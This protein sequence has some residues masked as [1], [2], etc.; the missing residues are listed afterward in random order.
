MGLLDFAAVLLVLFGSAA[1]LA[2]TVVES[3][4]QIPLAYDVDVVVVG[5]NTRGVS[6]A[7]AAKKAGASVFLMAE[8]PYLGED[9]CATYRLRLENGEKPAADMALAIFKDGTPTP[10]R[11]KRVLDDALIDAK[12]DFLYGCYPAA[13]LRDDSGNLSGIVMANR[14]GRQAVRAKV[15]IDATERGVL[16][17]MAGAMFEAYPAGQHAFKRIVVGGTPAEMAVVLPDML[18]IPSDTAKKGVTDT[19]TNKVYEYTL[20]IEMKDGSWS[21]FARADQEARNRTWQEGQ[22]DASESLFQIPP[23]PVKSRK[24]QAGSW[25]GADRIELDA[26]RPEKTGWIYVLGG[27]ADLS[28]EAAGQLLRPINGIELGLRVGE[29]AAKDAAKRSIV[30]VQDLIV[31][32]KAGGRDAGKIGEMLNGL[33]SKPGLTNAPSV[34]SPAGALPV[35]GEY[36]VVIV[37]GG[38]SGAPAAIAAA[39][40]GART[41]V[42]EYL[43][44][45]GGVGTLGRITKYWHGNKVGF[46]KEIDQDNGGGSGKSGGGWNIENKMEWFRKEIVKAG[47]E[48][49]FHSLACGSVVKNDRFTG[50][51]VATPL[52]TGVLLANT[53]IDA[54]G[55]AVIPAFAGAPCQEIGGDEISIQGTGLPTF[56]PGLGYLNG[57]W[58]FND[59]SDVLDMLR[60]FVVA[61]HKANKDAF[62]LGQLITTRA[63][64]RII[65]DIVISPMDILNKRTF[66]DTI[67]V[68]RSNFDNHGFSSHDIFMVTPPG[69]KDSLVGNIPYRALMP[70]GYDGVL[71]TGLGISAHGDAMPV[72]RMQPDVQN[73][74]YAAG[75][76]A[77]LAAKTGKTVRTIDVKELQK[78]LVE[79]SIIPPGMLTDADSYPVSDD[80]MK[81]AVSGVGKDYSGIS[82]VLTDTVRAIPLMK[83]A[84]KESTD[85]EAKLRFAHVLGMLGDG[86]GAATLIDKLKDAEWDKGWKFRGMGQFGPTTSYMDNLVIALG[87]TRE[88]RGMDVL[89]KMM[90][91][92][93]V[94]SEFSHCRAISMAFE[95]FGDNRA[96]KPL[97]DFLRQ[98]GV[99]GHALETLSENIEKTPGG[100]ADTTTR[101][102]SLREI[103][104]ARALYRCGDYEGLGEKILREYAGDLC[105]HYASHAK[106]VLNERS[107]KR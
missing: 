65:G 102:A 34:K 82:I 2:E 84:L 96:A 8:R 45:L 58:T 20:K 89:L 43:D 31:S 44:G 68:A 37:G 69:S 14:S 88:K 74:G 27:C 77:A 72:L 71:V 83:A 79:K 70:K 6:A 13:V 40:A 19:T 63:R 105:G 29:A 59:D 9:L 38:T 47:G 97:A 54:T 66:P 28:R 15:I 91:K 107:G 48:I 42:I 78:H 49:W 17:R 32:M 25:P 81:E 62:D 64:R 76:A 101:N 23:D 98:E 30:P 104:M 26:L 56:T 106:A 61:K 16:A 92:L 103:I 1:C 50:V 90:G 86:A 52:G 75:Y 3:E 80:A 41:L 21:S 95:T 35:L 60:M 53:V 24:P 18:I 46:T 85:K 99:M 33:R 57:D 67:T 12:V 36:D 93:T 73:Q 94:G 5:G 4:R 87:R 22:V 7:V 10:L 55:N 39:R 100:F 51:V 11:V